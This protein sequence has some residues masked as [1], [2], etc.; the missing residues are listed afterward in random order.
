MKK[1]ILLLSIF[2]LFLFSCSDAYDITQENELPEEEAY[3]TID[4]LK[5][6]LNGVYSAYGP[7]FGG[8]A[9]A[10]NDLFTDNMRRGTSNNGQGSDE[11]NFL[12]QPNSDLPGTMWINRYA[13]INRIN[14][15]LRAYDRL[16]NSFSDEDKQFA[17]HIKG[18]LLA[19]R[20]L[21]HFDLF[22]YFTVDY[23]NPSSLSVIKM[24]FVPDSPFQVF[25][26]NTVADI[27]AF[28][29]A[30]LT[31]SLTLLNNTPSNP[32]IAT[33]NT[34]FYLRPSAV[35]FIQC[36]LALLQGDYATAETLATTL[37]AAT[38]LSPKAAY[39]QMFTDANAGESIFKLSRVAGNNSIP[40][41]F[42]FNSSSAGPIDPYLQASRQLFNLF[43][44]TDIRRTVIFG[45]TITPE[46]L[47]ASNFPIRKYV[48]STDGP[49]INDVKLFRSSEL[50]LIIAECKARNNDLVGAATA[51]R[52]LRQ[53][54]VVSPVPAMPVYA[55]L[56]DALTDIL[57][58]RRK[59]FAFEG[60]RYL[61]LKR[62]G[63]EI[64]VGVNRLAEDAFTFNAPTSLSA[65]DHRFT[66]PIP[67]EEISA[68]PSIVQNPNY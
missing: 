5:S 32:D 53:I 54:R 1:S 63:G 56:N 49:T 10:F 19:L 34:V 47:A 57:V 24:N 23:K 26:R 13:T 45:A 60:H 25:P 43:P 3:V 17:D 33:Y 11:Y 50:K 2:S 29:K 38:P 39:Q 37:L 46:N 62:I 35:N 15:V 65:G 42:Y 31:E 20:A 59:E 66:L 6:G 40:N 12:M 36:R 22:Q 4:H 28:I 30:D 44:S 58:E 18:N 9:L 48:G 51:V 14:R 41:L 27:T 64:N 16:Y 61:D 7:D 67:T 52:E 21:C 55:T 8:D 68:N